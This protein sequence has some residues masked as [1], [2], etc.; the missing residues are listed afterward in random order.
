MHSYFITTWGITNFLLLISFIFG[1]AKY[2]VLKKEERQY[3][4]YIGFL[5][6]IEAAT[7]FLT[8][9]LHYKD[10]SFLYPIYI[11]GE[12]FLLTSLFMRKLDILKYGLIPVVILTLGYLIINNTFK[13]YF[14][15]DVVKVTSNIIIVC[16][17]GY[18]L[19]QQIKNNKS[20]NRFT[21]VDACIFFYYSVSVFIFVI[22]HQIAS[23]SEDNYYAIL[24]TNNILSSILYGSFI[25][26]FIKLKK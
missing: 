15:D 11:A 24:G 25:Y 8:V 5:L 2:S 18:T 26:T 12:F 10:T 23:L 17:A 4:F 9:V 3:V 20:V 1:I 14:N 21:L 6:F 22:Q 7:N 13:T 16:F 19:L